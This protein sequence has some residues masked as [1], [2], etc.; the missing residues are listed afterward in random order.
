MDS[1]S[2]RQTRISSFFGLIILEPEICAVGLATYQKVRIYKS[3]KI[4]NEPDLGLIPLS[5]A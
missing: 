4:Y 2:N 5:L 1:W 3:F